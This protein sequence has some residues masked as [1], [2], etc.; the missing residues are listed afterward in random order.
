MIN[1]LVNQKLLIN[2]CLI[3]YKYNYTFIMTSQMVIIK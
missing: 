3:N 2:Y 1:L